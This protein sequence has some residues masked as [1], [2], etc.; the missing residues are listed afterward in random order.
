MD[1]QTPASRATDPVSSYVA[2]K[3][4]TK[5]GKRKNQIDQIAAYA[6]IHL[7][8]TAGEIALGLGDDWDNVMVVL[9]V[10][11]YGYEAIPYIGTGGAIGVISSMWLHKRIR[12]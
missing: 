9:G 5:S 8:S 4:I 10:V 6:Q 11:H 12:K 1:I 2:E 3:Q 7:G